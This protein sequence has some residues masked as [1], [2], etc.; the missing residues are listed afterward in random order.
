MPAAPGRVPPET[1]EPSGDAL[2]AAI[3]IFPT[4]A[5]M[6]EAELDR[7]WARLR[8]I[9]EYGQVALLRS[10]GALMQLDALEIAADSPEAETIQSIVQSDYEDV[11]ESIE[12]LAALDA[13]GIED[14]AALGA[15][16]RIVGRMYESE[17]LSG[18]S[19]N[20]ALD[21]QLDAA[22]RQHLVIRRPGN[23]VLNA[24]DRGGVT[25]G[26]LTITAICR[27]CSAPAIKCALIPSK[28]ERRSSAP[29][30]SYRPAWGWGWLQAAVQIARGQP[31]AG[32][33]G[34]RLARSRRRHR[35]RLLRPAV[36]FVGILV[37]S[38]GRCPARSKLARAHEVLRRSC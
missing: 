34:R 36:I 13:L 33:R 28:A 8:T 26:I 27:C 12:T 24:E 29:F 1:A 16:F 2:A 18:A 21:E 20:T 32:D 31:Y 19:V 6:S 38:L 7:V 11:R 10:H 14:P 25:S 35:R 9:D 15:Q 3:A 4:L 23:R 5:D 22:L 30:L 37:V 17:Y